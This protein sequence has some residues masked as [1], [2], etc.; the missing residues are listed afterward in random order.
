MKIM[1]DVFKCI[2]TLIIELFQVSYNVA[3]FL[4]KNR[5]SVSTNMISLME[6]SQNSLVNEL[7]TSKLKDT[8]TLDMR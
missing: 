4:A 1:L 6:N 5:D 2:W 7:F 3:G 8:G